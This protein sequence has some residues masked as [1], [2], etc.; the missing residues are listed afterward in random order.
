MKI[1]F[2]EKKFCQLKTLAE[3]WDCSVDYLRD[4]AYKGVI[5]LWHPEG[6][7]SGRGVKVVVRS[8]LKAEKEGLIETKFE[9]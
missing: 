2:E 8:V 3:R 9:V 1:N 6:R 4:L 7:E 5:E